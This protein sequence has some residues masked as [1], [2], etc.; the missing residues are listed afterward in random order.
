MYYETEACCNTL[1][2]TQS[3]GPGYKFIVFEVKGV[4]LII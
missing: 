3:L 2:L 1:P 4:V